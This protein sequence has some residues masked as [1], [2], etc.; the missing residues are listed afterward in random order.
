MR[1]W[2]LLTVGMTLY[3]STWAGVVQSIS[4]MSLSVFCQTGEFIGLCIA[5][6]VTCICMCLHVPANS[7]HPA[8]SFKSLQVEGFLLCIRRNRLAS[9]V[10]RSLSFFKQQLKARGYCIKEFEG[11]IA[12]FRLREQAGFLYSKTQ[13]KQAFLKM[14]FMQELNDRWLNAKL[15]KFRLFCKQRCLALGWGSVGLSMPIC[16]E[17]AIKRLGRVRPRSWLREVPKKFYSSSHRVK[18]YVQVKPACD[19]FHIAQHLS[20]PNPEEY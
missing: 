13:V 1:C 7:C 2:I 3:V 15:R 9:D 10:E 5:N 6:R 11:L 19:L 18:G 17:S 8:S 14:P 20:C 12:R 4:L 16:S